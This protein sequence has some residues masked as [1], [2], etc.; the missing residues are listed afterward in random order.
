MVG[1]KAALYVMEVPIS[2]IVLGVPKSITRDGE[3]ARQNIAHD[4]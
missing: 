2:E 4:T 1:E 3:L